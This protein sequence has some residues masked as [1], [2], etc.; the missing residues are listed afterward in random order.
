MRAELFYI[1]LVNALEE[2]YWVAEV[3]VFYDLGEVD[4]VEISVAREASCEVDSGVVCSIESVA[5]PRLSRS[6]HRPPSPQRRSS[7]M[8]KHRV[9]C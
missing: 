6:T 1:D 5:Y 8:T 3:L 4:G 7:S 9:S 2:F